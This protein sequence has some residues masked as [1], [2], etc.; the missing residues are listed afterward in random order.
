MRAIIIDDKDARELVAQLELE[1]LKKNNPNTFDPEKPAT[2]DGMH[3][4]FHYVVVRWLQD[5][6]CN[7]VR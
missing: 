6:G 2:H 7:V 5:Q 1:R 3:G 4:L